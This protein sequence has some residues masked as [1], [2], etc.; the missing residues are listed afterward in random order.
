LPGYCLNHP[1]DINAR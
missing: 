1:P